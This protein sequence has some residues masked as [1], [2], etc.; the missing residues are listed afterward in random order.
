MGIGKKKPCKIFTSN[1]EISEFFVLLHSS[2]KQMNEKNEVDP[3]K[4]HPSLIEVKLSA[5]AFFWV[6]SKAKIILY[7]IKI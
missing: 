4:I 5:K 6:S 1:N 2:F 7:C 3:L